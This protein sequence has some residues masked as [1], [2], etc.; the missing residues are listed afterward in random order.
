[1]MIERP[2]FGFVF[3][4]FLSLASGTGCADRP[5]A[6][7]IRLAYEVVATLP[8]DITASTQ[9]LL[10]H[11]GAFYESTGGYGESTLRKSDPATGRVERLRD[12]PA[13]AFGEGLALR[14]G[15]L[16]QLEWKSGKGFIYDLESFE[17]VG[18][19]SY[20][21]EGWGL[22]Y[23]GEHFILSDGTARLRFLEPEGFSVAREVM[24]RNHLGP[25]DQL[26]E[27][28]FIEGRVYANRWYLDEIVSIDPATGRV[29]GILHLGGLQH[30]RP[31]DPDAVLNGIAYDPG[32][33]LVYVTGKR[34]P[35]VHVIRLREE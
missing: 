9:G 19:F 5:P 32:S 11:D 28:E 13:R 12:L 35:K 25:V 17:R 24:V 21:G 22:A 26:N 7:P 15:R 14:N 4:L 8:H 1:M 27:L 20:T 6:A 29:E 31:R 2:T 34:W 23:D 16:Y 30:P 33:G 18:E 10:F 3:A